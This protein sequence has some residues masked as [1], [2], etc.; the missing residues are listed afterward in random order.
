M[1]GFNLKKI[2]YRNSFL[3]DP[4]FEDLILTLEF[5]KKGYFLLINMKKKKNFLKFQK[6]V[7]CIM[8]KKCLHKKYKA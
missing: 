4:G 5:K 2:D 6:N 8:H 7:V 3:T 1:F